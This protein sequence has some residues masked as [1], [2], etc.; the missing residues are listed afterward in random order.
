MQYGLDNAVAVGP[1]LNGNLPET[2]GS[3]WD[4]VEAFPNL[5]FDDPLQIIEVTAL[6]QFI[7]A[8]KYGQIW[9]ITTTDTT[10]STKNVM[11]DITVDVFQG[12]DTGLLGIA[13]HPKFGKGEGKD[14]LYVWYRHKQLPQSGQYAY[15]RL[16]R[17]EVN[18]TTMVANPASAYVMINQFDRHQWHNGGGMFFDK[19]G[20]LYITVGDEG[21]A[22]DV[23]N[24]GQ[25]INEGLLAGMLRIDV[26][27]DASRSHPIRRQPLN[28]DTPPVGWPD[29]YSQG[30]Y[31]PNDNP[32]LSTDSLYLEEFYAIGLRSPHRATYDSVDEYIFVG[33]IGQGL[34]E[35][36]DLVVKGSNMQWPFQEGELSGFKA[37]PDSLIGIETPPFFDY[38]RSMGTSVIGGVVYRGSKFPALYG[39][40]IFGDH[41]VRRIWSLD[42]LTAELDYLAVVPEFGVGS[43]A[44]ISSFFSDSKGEIYVTK[45][46]GSSVDGGK[47]YKL[48]QTSTPDPAPATLSATGAFSD[49]T[50]M[51]PQDFVIPYDMNVPFWSDNAKKYR[52]MIVPN[53]GTHNTS[54]EQVVYRKY[55]AFDWPIGTVFIKHFEY[56]MDDNDPTSLKKIET[57]FIVKGSD[58]SIYGLT[59]KWR[60]DQ[61]DA[62]LLSAGLLDTLTIQTTIGPREVHWYYPGETECAFCHNESAGGTLGPKSIQLNMDINYPRT[63]RTANQLKTLSHIGVF[64]NRP[65]TSALDE[66]PTAIH[67]DE[68]EQ[69]LETR[70]KSY[71]DSN[72]GYCHRP[73]TSIRANFDARF[74][75]PLGS[76]NLV[77]G[78]LEHPKENES[79]N[80]AIVPGK[81]DQSMLFRRLSVVHD[82]I[83]M[84]PL[85]KNLMDSAGVA[86]VEE[87]ILSMD[88]QDGLSD[89]N[90][91]RIAHY[92]FEGTFND[93]IGDADG[94]S[95]N[96]A[97]IAVDPVRGNVL[98]TDGVDDYMS[99][100]AK[101]QFYLGEDD[102][103]FSV[104]F[105]F[106][107]RT[108][109][110]GVDRPIV[111][112]GERHFHNTFAVWMGKNDETVNYRA[113]STGTVYD[114]GKTIAEIPLNTWTHITYVKDGNK[115]Y[116]YLDGVFQGLTTLAGETVP[117]NHDLYVGAHPLYGAYTNGAF[118]DLM[119]YDRALTADEAKLL[120]S[121]T[122]EKYLI[123]HWPLNVD[124]KEIVD[125]ADAFLL[126]NPSFVEDAERGKVAS[127]DG[128]NDF[129]MAKHELHLELG[130]ANK[131]FSLSLWINLK[132]DFTGARRTI[133]KKG[134]T[135]LENNFSIQMNGAD[136]HLI[137]QMTTT[138]GLEDGLS[139]NALSLNTWNHV[140]YSYDGT[141]VNLYING[142]FDSDINLIGD[143]EP[144]TGHIYIGD[145]PWN[146]PV[147][148][149]LDDIKILN[150]SLSST[151]LG[152][153][154]M[155]TKPFAIGNDVYTGGTL[156]GSI[157]NLLINKTDIFT[158]NTSVPVEIE[159]EAMRFY[160]QRLAN[161]ITP[162]VAKVGAT[163]YEV[164]AIGTTRTSS[165]YVVGENRFDF[166][167]GDTKVVTL[168]P[169]E[170]L[171][172]GF[173]DAN[174]DGSGTGINSVI[175]FGSGTDEYWFTGSNSGTGSAIISEGS[176]VTEGTFASNETKDYKFLIEATMLGSQNTLNQ[177]I[178]VDKVPVAKTTDGTVSLNANS[179]FN[180]P[181]D[182]K[183]I[184]GPATLEGPNVILSG[185]SGQVVIE[186]S[187]QG[188]TNL[189]PATTERVDFFVAPTGNGEG[190]GTGLTAT[191]YN[192]TAMTSQALQRIDSTIDFTWGS[193]SPDASVNPLTFA[194]VWEGEIESPFTEEITFKTTTDDGVR[195]WV[196]GQLIVD[197][198]NDQSVNSNFGSVNLTA[199]V[200]VPIRM[201]YYQNKV[202]AEAQLEWSSN[203][204]ATQIVPTSFLYP[205]NSSLPI[206]LSAFDV[207]LIGQEARLEWLSANEIGSSHY[208][209][210]R[211]LDGT[212]FEQLADVRARGQSNSSTYYEWI[213]SKPHYGVN[214]YR[215]KM[216]DTDGSFGYS[217]IRS[218]N[219]KGD[220][221]W[222]YPNPGKIG[223]EL[224][225][226]IT[227]KNSNVARLALMDLSG[228][229]IRQE[230]WTLENGQAVVK[231]A[232]D[233]LAPGGYLIV[234]TAGDGTQ[235]IKKVL[236]SK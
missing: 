55:D 45:L 81:P 94:V 61:T 72:C 224:R 42:P 99:V 210:E 90:E 89:L 83:S 21:G 117:N 87:W 54:D 64:E 41:T 157:A 143:P 116:I 98:S 104:A 27:M 222:V 109:S 145:D 29:S 65:D 200:K 186:V 198:W 230:D 37:K 215:L 229:K 204:M 223:Q 46:F 170:S 165:E 185:T 181:L 38:A 36:I 1:Y 39:K 57:R 235:L 20:Y 213:D 4:V 35:E 220:Q 48:V 188:N 131:P 91:G 84:P 149:L 221:L 26:D 56:Q 103:D 176:D 134:D 132:Q 148:A 95:Q 78:L 228:R 135:N 14:Y 199:W 184:S 69:P 115:L 63:G 232:T 93:V 114:G 76:M 201:E 102:A 101:P 203:S 236:I 75:T 209:I 111:H 193:K 147:N 43:K 70:V 32:F 9:S 173:M 120:A 18:T 77:M 217:D 153:Q 66:L 208:T 112:K 130:R 123:A 23:Y 227:F 44:G 34:R 211:S 144:N 73:N 151:D 205:Q 49:L 166:K 86:L 129:M 164:L 136:N 231:I 137:Y 174:P 53:D 51:T 177:T 191:Y 159:L 160:A 180:M 155:D 172:P 195:L 40:Y 125:N 179:T 225:A 146:S 196:D 189:N 6:N 140:V 226:S 163:N 214:Y 47:I 8:G 168:Q 197:N 207:Q 219:L 10:I 139:A 5:T 128:V 192:D 50:N 190:S 11:L 187:Q 206:E 162:F 133:I 16:V 119:I 79:E 156:D 100:A 127:L 19:D 141:K 161:P 82:E 13:A 108:G 178:S 234:A 216:V 202:Y 59:Y 183:L 182:Y 121:D 138:H 106:M 110:V 88:E 152:K 171:Y 233:D 33:D 52:W 126:N 7:V 167:D 22:Q 218:I 212:L 24:N 2:G 169:G 3:S 71:L 107:Q 150:K 60:D 30:Y 74:K 194:V 158:N 92:D 25:K 113:S 12:G 105:W 85:A 62:D 58:E 31:I 97:S 96:G 17:Y 28:P 15:L 142:S 122:E 68:V 175:P 124:G 154:M 67:G 80:R 118:D